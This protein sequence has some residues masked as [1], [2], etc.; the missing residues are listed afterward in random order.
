[1]IE[2]RVTSREAT[3]WLVVRAPGG[4][5]ERKIEAIIDTGFNRSPTRPGL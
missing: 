1:M 5:V 3:V 2:G 4:T